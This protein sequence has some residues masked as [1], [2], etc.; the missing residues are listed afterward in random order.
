MPE[1]L[2]KRL[3]GTGAGLR[4]RYK[5]R[6]FR[7][8]LSRPF[9]GYFRSGFLTVFRKWRRYDRFGDLF[10]YLQYFHLEGDQIIP[11]FFSKEKKQVKM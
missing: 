4:S 2:G 10:I 5:T 3:E 6:R 7:S 11:H 9:G 1:T 8:L